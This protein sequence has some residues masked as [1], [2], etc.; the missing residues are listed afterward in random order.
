MRD[1]RHPT[2]GRASCATSTI[3]P[4]AQGASYRNMAADIRLQD[5]HK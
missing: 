4:C 5:A 1:I 3:A 2:V